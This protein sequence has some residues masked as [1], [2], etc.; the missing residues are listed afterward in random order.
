MREWILSKTWID[1]PS[2]SK[3]ECN[4]TGVRVIFGE[5]RQMIDVLA[6]GLPT[7]QSTRCLIGMDILNTGVFRYDGKSTE[8]VFYA[9]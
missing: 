5:T 3:V 6:T 9:H 2:G 4:Q 1:T 8:C 7:S